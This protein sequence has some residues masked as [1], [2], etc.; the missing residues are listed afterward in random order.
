[1]AVDDDLGALGQPDELADLLGRRGV[2][3]EANSSPTS[4]CLA[5]GMCP[6]RGSHL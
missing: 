1:M 3:G 6:W 2:P 5:P 4:T